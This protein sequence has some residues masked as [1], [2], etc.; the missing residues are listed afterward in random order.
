[1]VEVAQY[2]QKDDV[3]VVV[4]KDVE[5]YYSDSAVVRVIISGPVLRSYLSVK[6]PR[7]VF[8]KGLV[9]NFYDTQHHKQSRLVAKYGIK[10]DKLNKVVVQDSV[11]VT[12]I[13]KE[14]LE[15]EELFWDE[16]NGKISTDKFVKVSTANE[17]IYGY[18]L[19]ANDDFSYWKIKAVTGRFESQN[20]LDDFE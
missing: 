6:E 11:V 14:K 12:T 20:M 3:Q 13:R 10:Y 17:V 19:E 2:F 18:G 4:A 16:K 1:M 15:T 7:S 8:E 9:A 5:I